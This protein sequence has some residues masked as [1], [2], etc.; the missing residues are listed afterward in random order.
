VAPRDGLERQLTKIWETALDIKPIGVQDNFFSRKR[1]GGYGHALTREKSAFANRGES[2][3]CEIRAL[4]YVSRKGAWQKIG[5]FQVFF[6]LDFP[7]R[8]SRPPER[9]PNFLRDF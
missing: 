1:S 3:F 2:T 7:A 5:F 6:A 8:L 9:L 4:H